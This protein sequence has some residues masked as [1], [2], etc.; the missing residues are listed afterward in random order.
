[1]SIEFQISNSE[2]VR[3]VK[4]I[5]P[6]VSEDTRGT[7]WTSY[8][9]SNLDKLLPDNL[10]FK[11]DKFSES[12]GNVLR[13]I[14]GDAK[15]WKL[16]T[17]VFGEIYQVAVDCRK[18]SKTYGNWESFIINKKCQNLI[19]IPPGVG[20]AY[21]VKTEFAVYHYKLAYLDEY[22]DAE[23]QFTFPWNDNKFNVDWPCKDPILSER[24]SLR[25]ASET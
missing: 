14:H 12:K 10:S 24:D 5:R 21:Y 1:M 22:N 6:S 4:I 16:V 20:N 7:V 17:S 19:L 13:G 18:D 8:L 3:G 2:V 11:H 23:D 15:T 25:R 9:E